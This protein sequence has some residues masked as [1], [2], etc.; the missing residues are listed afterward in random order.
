MLNKEVDQTVSSINIFS[1]NVNGLNDN[2]KRLDIIRHY[3]YTLRA[4]IQILIDTILKDKDINKIKN[5]AET[6]NY[7]C[8]FQNR[9]DNP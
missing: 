8:I 9:K 1:Y 2:D 6:L 7:S 3:L 4:D 5:Q